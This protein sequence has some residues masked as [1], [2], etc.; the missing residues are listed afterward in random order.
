[1]YS[2]ASDS[3]K[4]DRKAAEMGYEVEDWANN[5]LG[6]AVGWWTKNRGDDEDEEA[7]AKDDLRAELRQRATARGSEP[8]LVAPLRTLG[9]ALARAH[10]SGDAARVRDVIAGLDRCKVD[11]ASLQAL[12]SVT[13]LLGS[14]R[15]SELGGVAERARDLVAKWKRIL[16]REEEEK[17][18]LESRRRA[19][20]AESD[21][22]LTR[23]AGRGRALSAAASSPR[24]Y[25]LREVLAHC[26][27]PT[28]EAAA[29]TYADVKERCDEQLARVRAL[30]AASKKPRGLATVVALY[31]GV[32]DELEA[33]G[34]LVGGVGEDLVAVHRALVSVE[35]RHAL[36]GP[37]VVDALKE[38]A[39]DESQA[40]LAEDCL[41]AH[42]GA[43]LLLRNHLAA[44]APEL[45]NP[46]GSATPDRGAVML[47][48][49]AYDLLE[50][51][52]V[53][54]SGGDVSAFCV[55]HHVTY[56]VHEL[57]KNA[58]VA[59]VERRIRDHG[60]DADDDDFPLSPVEVAL[61]AGDGEVVVEV[62][63]RGGGMPEDAIAA[64][65]ALRPGLARYDRLDDPGGSYNSGSLAPV[66]GVGM[67]LPMAKLY[68][69]HFGGG[70]RLASDLGAGTTT[71]TVSLPTDVGTPEALPPPPPAANTPWGRRADLRHNSAQ[72]R[73]GGRWYA[74][75][76]ALLGLGYV[77]ALV[78]FRA[79][80]GRAAAAPPSSYFVLPPPEP[81]SPAA[82]DVAAAPRLGS[83]RRRRDGRAD[84][85]RGRRGD[86]QR[87]ARRARR[88]GAGRRGDDRA[89]PPE[90]PR[91]DL[92]RGPPD[93]RVRRGRELVAAGRGAAAATAATWSEAE[94]RALRR[95]AVVR[96]P[97][98]PPVGEKVFEGLAAATARAGGRA[99]FVVVLRHPLAWAVSMGLA[100]QIQSSEAG[101]PGHRHGRGL[102]P[103]GDD[104]VSAFAFWMEAVEA[105]VGE[106]LTGVD[107]VVVHSEAAVH[108]DVAAAVL[109]MWHLVRRECERERGQYTDE[110]KL[111][112]T[113][114]H[115]DFWTVKRRY[116]CALD[117]YGYSMRSFESLL[118]CSKLCLGGVAAALDSPPVQLELIEGR[119]AARSAAVAFAEANGSMPVRGAAGKRLVGDVIV[120]FFKVYHGAQSAGGRGGMFMRMQQ[121]VR[122]SSTRCSHAAGGEADVK[123]L[124][125]FVTSLTVDMHF[126]AAVK[127]AQYWWKEPKL[128]SLPSRRS[129][130]AAHSQP[131]LVALT[132]DVHHIRA[133]EAFKDVG[134][135]QPLNV[136]FML[137]WLKRREL[138]LYYEAADVLT[139]SSEDADAIAADLDLLYGASPAVDAALAGR[140][141][142]PPRVSWAPFVQ[143]DVG[144]SD[145][146]VA[147]ALWNKT[148]LLYVGMPHPLA[149][150]A[151]RWFVR[152]VLPRLAAVLEDEKGMP[153]DF[154]DSHATLHLAGGGL[155]AHRW[156]Q[157]YR[158]APRAAQRRVK[159]VGALSDEELTAEL[160]RYRRV[161][162]APL[163]NNTGI[164]T[165]VVNAMSHGLPVVTTSGGC[166]GL[167]LDED[168]DVLL[169]A[170]DALTFARAVADLLV[171]D[172]L[173][174]RVSENSVRHVADHLS[175]DSLTRVV[176][177]VVAPLDGG[178]EPPEDA[179][180]RPPGL[181]Y[182][183][184][185]DLPRARDGPLAVDASCAA[186]DGA[187]S[188]PSIAT[189][190]ALS[191]CVASDPIADAGFASCGGS[192]SP[193]GVRFVDEP[194]LFGWRGEPWVLF[195][196]RPTCNARGGGCAWCTSDLQ[197][198]QYLARVGPDGALAAPPL[199]VASTRDA[200]GSVQRAFAPFVGGDALYLVSALEPHVVLR[201]NA[202]AEARAARPAGADWTPRVWTAP[203]DDVEA[204]LVA[205]APRLDD[206]LVACDGGS[207]CAVLA[208]TATRWPRDFWPHASAA[209]TV[210][211]M[212]LFRGD[213]A[214]CTNPC[215]AEEGSETHFDDIEDV[216]VD[217]VAGGSEDVRGRHRRR[218]LVPGARRRRRRRAAP[219]TPVELDEHDIKAR[220]AEEAAR[221]LEYDANRDG[222]ISAE[223]MKD[224]RADEAMG[225]QQSVLRDVADRF[226]SLDEYKSKL[227]AL[228]VLCVFVLVYAS[229][230]YMQADVKVKFDLTTTLLDSLAPTDPATGE[231][232]STFDS[233][234]AI[235]EWID[236]TF[237]ATYWQNPQC[238]DNACYLPEEYPAMF[239]Y[240]CQ[241]DCGVQTQT[242]KVAV[243]A[244]ARYDYDKRR[245]YQDDDDATFI[246]SSEASEATFVDAT[247][248]QI[249]SSGPNMGVD[250]L[251]GETICWSDPAVSF[252]ESAQARLFVYDVPD[253][254]WTISW[255]APLG[256]MDVEILV[257][258]TDGGFNDTLSRK[259]S[260]YEHCPAAPD[261]PPA[262][263]NYV[264]P[265]NV[266]GSPDC[267]E[268]ERHT[269]VLLATQAATY[270]CA[271]VTSRYAEGDYGVF[272]NLTHVSYGD[273]LVGDRDRYDC[274]P[275]HDEAAC[276]ESGAP[277]DCCAAPGTGSC[278][279]GFEMGHQF[280]A[281]HAPD[282]VAKESTY[283][284]TCC[285]P[286]YES[287]PAAPEPVD[288]AELNLPDDMTPLE[289]PY[290]YWVDESCDDATL[291]KITV[292]VYVPQPGSESQC[293]P[294]DAVDCTSVYYFL[295]EALV[296]G[297]NYV[298]LCVPAVDDY[299]CEDNLLESYVQDPFDTLWYTQDDN[300]CGEDWDDADEGH[301]VVKLASF[302]TWFAD[303][304]AWVVD[305][306]GGC[307]LAD[308]AGAAATPQ[309]ARY[310]EGPDFAYF[311]SLGYSFDLQMFNVEVN[312]TAAARACD[313]PGLEVKMDAAHG[314]WR[315]SSY[316][317]AYQALDLAG[318]AVSAP[319]ARYPLREEASLATMGTPDNGD[320][321]TSNGDIW[322]VVHVCGSND[323]STVFDFDWNFLP[324]SATDADFGTGRAWNFF[325]D[326]AS[327]VGGS[328]A[329][330]STNAAAAYNNFT[331]PGYPLAYTKLQYTHPTAQQC[332][333]PWE[334]FRDMDAAYVY[335]YEEPLLMQTLVESGV[336]AAGSDAIAFK[337]GSACP[338]DAPVE[339]VLS[340]IFPAGYGDL[341]VHVSAGS[342]GQYVSR[343]QASPSQDPDADGR[344]FP[345]GHLSKWCARAGN[346]TLHVYTGSGTGDYG[347]IDG[348]VALSYVDA[349]ATSCL[350]SAYVSGTTVKFLPEAY[351]GEFY[352][353]DDDGDDY[354][355]YGDDGD[356]DWW[357]SERTS[358]APSRD[359]D[360]TADA[361]D[362]AS[363]R[364]W[365]YGSNFNK[366]RDMSMALDMS[367][368]MNR[369]T[370]PPTGAPTAAAASTTDKFAQQ[371][372]EEATDDAVAYA[373]PNVTR[374]IVMGSLRDAFAARSNYTDEWCL[375]DGAYHLEAYDASGAGWAGGTLS[376]YD[377]SNCLLA[378]LAPEAFDAGPFSGSVY[379]FDVAMG[380]DDDDAPRNCQP[381]CVRKTLDAYGPPDVDYGCCDFEAA[382][383]RTFTVDSYGFTYLDDEGAVMDANSGVPVIP[384][385]ARERFVATRN[386]ILVGLVL[387]QT[388]N[389][390]RGCS[391]YGHEEKLY[392]MCRGSQRSEERFG[393]DSVFV[394]DSTLYN[395]YGDG[396]QNAI[397]VNKSA[398]SRSCL[399]PGCGDFYAADELMDSGKA[400]GFS[401]VNLDKTKALPA[402]KARLNAYEG[403][404][405]I[406]D[407]NVGYDR[408][409]ELLTYVREG[410]YVDYY[411]D[412][413]RVELVTF[414]GEVNMYASTL[415]EITF[416]EEGQIDLYSHVRTVGMSQYKWTDPDNRL[417][418]FLELIFVT[419][420][421]VTMYFEMREFASIVWHTGSAMGYLKSFWN[422]ID[423]LSIVFNITCIL[424]CSLSLLANMFHLRD[425]GAGLEEATKALVRLDNLFEL[426]AQYNV[427]NGLNII[428]ILMRFLNASDF[429]PKLGILT[430]TFSRAAGDLGHFFLILSI[431]VGGF[432]FMGHL[433]FGAD[434]SYFS[435]VP[436]SLLSCV[437]IM[438]YGDTS[439]SEAMLES[440]KDPALALFFHLLYS[441]LVVL[442]LVNIV[443]AI[444]VD[445][446]EKANG[447]R[448]KAK[449]V[450]YDFYTLFQDLE[451][452]YRGH[453]MGDV[454]ARKE[455]L[456]VLQSAV[457]RVGE[458]DGAPASLHGAPRRASRPSTTGPAAARD[459][460]DDKPALEKQPSAQFW[461]KSKKKKP[462]D[463][464]KLARTVFAKKEELGRMIIDDDDEGSD[465]EL[466]D[467]VKEADVR[468]RAFEDRIDAKIA[469]L[470]ASVDALGNPP[471]RDYIAELR[472]RRT[473]LISGSPPVAAR[474][475]EED[476][477]PG[478]ESGDEEDY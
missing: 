418:I 414:N 242:T 137:A 267:E 131:G 124:F 130:P 132:D 309:D 190:G 78:G 458:V 441:F 126:R 381:A 354:Y 46:G 87:G 421:S 399:P 379:A 152:E 36:F 107:C 351:A 271:S 185:A 187:L 149:I 154:V 272:T 397:G 44:H 49:Y 209:V 437:N 375:D 214:A 473:F 102:T 456:R 226:D 431:I 99:T 273:A 423:I 329:L 448:H 343:L 77:A 410:S 32:V 158:D 93:E 269:A 372:T 260:S 11:T 34:G 355:A 67:G 353:S 215:D 241:A 146:P 321:M 61:A 171:D 446:F 298:D 251:T 293:D 266:H 281:C 384:D 250:L 79:L 48:E 255:D 290:Y 110:E 282:D 207:D 202:T 347:S 279:A 8:K 331:S 40:A 385:E 122:S 57:L 24:A 359:F 160:L 197:I 283:L 141:R 328:T 449:S 227:V 315:L 74:W 84:G 416:T 386:R 352:E 82:A 393:F 268:G 47:T 391:V 317:R 25:T 155:D 172:A 233:V 428:L 7:K 120:A 425:G 450:V 199:P 28:A 349:D 17:A 31:S 440:G 135:R 198:L 335:A 237:L 417:R 128:G 468:T 218:R 296:S 383:D 407:V 262:L 303:A 395:A 461:K 4:A 206:L 430:R 65:L 167:G 85:R 324:E 212:F 20:A 235:Y 400:D 83:R 188:N 240:G 139:V 334:S 117:G 392:D 104:V 43:S 327:F 164:A 412:T 60:R 374:E 275:D 193:Y 254:E 243:R 476:D 366:S 452:K 64:C 127:K 157:A 216:D 357:G 326:A 323:T 21:A 377:E 460:G 119:V 88:R 338:D 459:G 213:V 472:A 3:A 295:V 133:A 140:S 278:D 427:Y 289:A 101:G 246:V 68:A 29:T 194:R 236:E 92:R 219:D 205:V 286:S 175:K 204:A 51:P 27:L 299:A 159:H 148:G 413:L 301:V 371:T 442:V 288:V 312:T 153:K 358:G 134:A 263:E 314:T 390:E 142:A 181:V 389:S 248:F 118:S 144:A 365:Y 58:L 195:A 136:A 369:T 156:R 420:F 376:L 69:R 363:L 307:P 14:L 280:S 302:G 129:R 179:A 313:A 457:D 401:F 161:F 362:G 121:V 259:Y 203:L 66:S 116:E 469:H 252:E 166:R 19:A 73:S 285:H 105:L 434:V 168:G 95:E 30:E 221:I 18:R 404:P 113:A 151:V 208:P 270:V 294:G 111:V 150:P 253:G 230:L 337:D 59:T 26:S 56:V 424:N 471:D 368:M 356:D 276:L 330:A 292:A 463:T 33:A 45:E 94:G 96:V 277:G 348:T 229:A 109:A 9:G 170:D 319:P 201:V 86:G 265:E 454:A 415:F 224:M 163:F 426:Y 183:P 316:Q 382:A 81:W 72:R 433:L 114:R 435:T 345:E 256:A 222:K 232:A 13:R 438:V 53:A 100:R 274:Y 408:S 50:P 189:R 350:V 15:K 115:V 342:H 192:K 174:R 245:A 340:L 220:G 341:Q 402:E 217:G 439:S 466:E 16:A 477:P 398:Y 432:A 380:G 70:L 173:W 291:R 112:A 451:I 310:R 467:I 249:C 409:Q 346:Y 370:R 90:Q 443:L 339:L 182:A 300:V 162:V 447:T 462:V 106:C 223:E 39:I 196:G 464:H 364:L 308:V 37:S 318:A 453:I 378:Q 419:M 89:R 165:K 474:S 405:L 225:I 177:G 478:G 429:Q 445:N 305:A 169:V 91:H 455:A 367:P 41:A 42:I 184:L 231:Y 284:Y 176:R 10:K 297:L 55:P 210:E 186:L 5:D 387:Q 6:T 23:L 388:R 80:H 320:G 97:G 332:A 38:G 287:L 12:K 257:N 333:D 123:A 200:L 403:Y 444:I 145:E 336:A 76:V 63:D 52:V 228:T 108:D 98:A 143:T 178:G 247:S 411:T 373:T 138:A 360:V 361:V 180:E 238:G 304:R 322:S 475:A 470:Q 394:R 35:Q 103:F 2:A 22:M 54:V 325:E 75:L 239:A 147:G 261:E 234:D 244:T 125:L 436:T 191:R 71:A 344:A 422:Y 311:T 465:A 62:T 264:A 306:D 211:V 406:F 1:M 258:Y 396:I